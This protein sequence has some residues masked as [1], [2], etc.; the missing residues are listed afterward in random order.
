[1]AFRAEDKDELIVRF[2][3]NLTDCFEE[4]DDIAPFQV[5]GL[6][7]AKYRVE[8][9]A[10]RAIESCPMFAR[11]EIGGAWNCSRHDMILAISFCDIYGVDLWA[12]FRS[13]SAH[14]SPLHSGANCLTNAA[15]EST[16]CAQRMCVRRAARGARGAS[17]V[18]LV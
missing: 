9:S 6:R 14:V 15:T 13:V 1:V 12:P 7:M 2:V 18:Q 16:K 3:L 17:S 8:R 10:V 4:R 5:M 11:P